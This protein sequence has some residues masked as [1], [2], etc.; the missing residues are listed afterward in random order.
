MAPTQPDRRRAR[1]FDTFWKHRYGPAFRT[2]YLLFL[3]SF[4]IFV[5]NVAVAVWIVFNPAPSDP[6]TSSDVAASSDAAVSGNVSDAAAPAADVADQP[7][8]AEGIPISINV[9]LGAC[10]VVCLILAQRFMLHVLGR[11]AS[12]VR[13]TAARSLAPCLPWLALGAVLP[14][15]GMLC[16]RF[17]I[18]PFFQRVPRGSGPGASPLTGTA[19]YCR[20]A[21]LVGALQ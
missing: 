3:A 21:L 17:S 14:W 20:E 16:C 15:L 11:G 9:V 6:S 13:S 19:C 1:S 4:P 8:F 12:Q 18:P 7:T 2:I 5:A 10:L